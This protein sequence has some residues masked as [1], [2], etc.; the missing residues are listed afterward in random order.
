[1]GRS[2][3]KEPESHTG[4]CGNRLGVPE[5]QRGHLCDWGVSEGR[6]VGEAH[7][8][9]R[10]ITQGLLSH[11]PSVPGGWASTLLRAGGSSVLGSP[12]LTRGSSAHPQRRE[13]AVGHPEL[14]LR[15]AGWCLPRLVGEGWTLLQPSRKQPYSTDVPARPWCRDSKASLFLVIS[16]QGR[17]YS[18]YWGY[19]RAH[20]RKTGTN[21]A[22]GGSRQQTSPG[23]AKHQTQFWVLTADRV[24]PGR[25]G[26]ACPGPRCQH[27]WWRPL[28][29]DSLFC[30]SP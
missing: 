19:G 27:C 24:R 16:L 2:W 7:R 23:K 3:G 13:M 21:R 8:A 12:L 30:L 22:L 17:G 5:K 29:L 4:A 26:L 15:R 9:E 6:G 18:G 14:R 10:A 1:M 28:G 25:P 11:C 20:D